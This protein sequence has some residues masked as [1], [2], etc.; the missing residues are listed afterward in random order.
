MAFL[1]ILLVTIPHM[2]FLILIS[3]RS[4]SSFKAAGSL[5]EARFLRVY[6][7]FKFDSIVLY[8]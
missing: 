7:F 4:V 8:V 2:V 5:L 1:S 6:V 3:K